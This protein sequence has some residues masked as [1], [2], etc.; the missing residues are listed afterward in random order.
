MSLSFSEPSADVAIERRST[1]GTVVVCGVGS[2]GSRHVANLLALGHEDLVLQRTGLGA[3]TRF[4]SD[5]ACERDLERALAGRPLA[6]VIANP[7][8][9]HVPTALAA[10]R[11]GAHLLIEKPLSHS[12]EGVG[13]LRREVERRGLLTLVGYQLRFHPSLQRVAAWIDGG[14][15]GEIVSAHAH[16]GECL[17]LWHPWE[18]YRNSYSARRELGGGALL[19]LSH[20]FDY[21]RLLLGEVR[22]VS[23]ELGRR[24]GLEIDVE[25]VVQVSLQ[26]AN[27]V[28]GSVYLD[29]VTR[30]KRHFLEIV[31]RQGRLRWSEADATAELFDGHGVRVEVCRPPAGFERNTPY[32]DEMAHFLRCLSGKERPL[33]TL[34]DGIEALR[35]CRAAL[36]SAEEGRRVAL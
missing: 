12:L 26:F 33:C 36:L 19:T 10:A 14:A 32:L 9:L 22:S 4:P 11:A 18:D 15:L 21:L 29:Y 3:S 23:A 20:P 35:I 34:D 1:P 16:W 7:T 8:A 30:P 6:V 25:D 13:E 2:A 31:G 17:R 5:L 27:G 28:L 24:S